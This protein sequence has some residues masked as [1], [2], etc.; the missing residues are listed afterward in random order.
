[1]GIREI[2]YCDISGSEDDVSPHELHID[3]LR[4]EIDLADPEY[5][6]LLELLRPYMDAGRLEPSAPDTASLPAK[7]QRES[8][9]S[10]HPRLTATERQQLR[11]WAEARGIEVPPNN[12]FKRTLVEQWQADTSTTI[13]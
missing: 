4:V 2:R 12:R 3:Q 8:R 13:S 1:M 5:R 9:A 7:P 11:G 6:K 10:T